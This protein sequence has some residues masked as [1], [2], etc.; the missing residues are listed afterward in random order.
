MAAVNGPEAV[1]VA[2]E[3][4]ALEALLADCTRQTVRAR[5]LPV[6][7]AAHSAQVT[8][9]GDALRT[10]LAGVRPRTPEVPLYSTVTGDVVDGAVLDADYWYRNLREPV[11]F[12]GATESLLAAGHDLFVE[13]SPHPV[14]TAAV[15]Q[16]AER[17]GRPVGAVGTVRRDD[18][19]TD[20]L[21]TS[22]AEAWTHGAPVDW[23]AVLPPPTGAHVALPTYA[24]QH[25]RYWL[26]TPGR[27][28]DAVTAAA[29]APEPAAGPPVTD[30]AAELAAR[31]A[32]LDETDRRRTV[33]DLV[34]AHAAAQLGH[35]G[36][37][38][39]EPDRPFVAAGFDSMLAVTFRTG[40]SAAT[41]IELPP[42]VVFDH[43]TPAGLAAHLHERLAAPPGP[44]RPV[45]A[46]LDRLADALA[47][48]GTDTPDADE[49]G[50]RLRDLLSTWNSRR[51]RDGDAGG[52]NGADTATATADELFELL[53]NNYGA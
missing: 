32:P 38:A 4:A 9:V 29:T 20:R 6:D 23:A 13:M 12:A 47:G 44:E 41:G 10:A 45:L 19:G 40:L 27:S 28:A 21:L 49:I 16:T 26:P 50:I 51:P 5:R 22:L 39:V 37:A 35:S 17:A 25:Q 34:L 11:A 43:P 42:T 33:L 30:P 24:F 48:A 14:L 1:V 15:T 31:L 8:D 53:D 18:G 3:P 52:A 2:G 36:T 46:Q 7:Y